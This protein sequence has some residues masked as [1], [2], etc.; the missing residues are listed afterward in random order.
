MKAIRVVLLLGTLAASTGAW[1]QTVVDYSLSLLQGG[2]ATPGGEV[3]YA[4]VVDAN[5]WTQVQEPFVVRLTVPPG[6]EP[7]A[8]CFG[9]DGL[10]AFDAEARVLSWS[11]RMDNEVLPQRSC[12]LIFRVAP[13][14]APGTV[15][16]LQGTLTTSKPDPNPANDSATITSVVLPA[17]DLEVTGSVDLQRYRPGTAVTHTFTVKNLGPLDAHD[18][19]IADR[20]PLQTELVSFEQV[21]GP[22][23]VFDTLPGGPEIRFRILTLP[24]GADATFRLV[25]KPTPSLG[26]ADVVNR[27]TVSS[28]SVDF[29]ER[30]NE[31]FQLSHAGPDA[32]LAIKSTRGDT[33]TLTITNRGPDTVNDVLVYNTLQDDGSRYDFVERVQYG[34]VTPSQGTCAAPELTSI[35]QTPPPPEF[36]SVSCNLGTLAPGATA[37]ITVA[38]ERQPGFPAFRHSASVSPA[39]NDPK[40]TNNVTQVEFKAGRR[41][42]VRLRR[43][44]P[45]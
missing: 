31:L 17:S 42:A 16:T 44:S 29:F 39:H 13:S 12:P 33:I 35:F 38:I 2:V 15:L 43:S 37:T 28:T 8:A 23:G 14:V 7:P 19:V 22:A 34:N 27:V 25:V 1:G 32:D 3:N 24:N 18:V 9:S 36:W 4:P 6:L 5:W 30:N 21:T 41:R 26:V 20:L 40:A 10:I 45:R 11:A